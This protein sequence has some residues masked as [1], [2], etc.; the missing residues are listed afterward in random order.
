MALEKRDFP[1]ESGN[2]DTYETNTI[3]ETYVGPCQ[4][5]NEFDLKTKDLGSVIFLWNSKLSKGH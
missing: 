5:L 1:P 3:Q 2:V 4:I